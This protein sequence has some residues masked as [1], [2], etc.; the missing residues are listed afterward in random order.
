M[1]SASSHQ[2][3]AL[4]WSIMMP[5]AISSAGDDQRQQ[6]AQDQ[7]ETGAWLTEHDQQRAEGGRED[8]RGQRHERAE[9]AEDDRHPGRDIHVGVQQ[10]WGCQ[11]QLDAQ[12]LGVAVYLVEAVI[13]GG[14]CGRLR[15]NSGRDWFT[16]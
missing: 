4:R 3:V 14:L 16:G 1:P 5:P 7:S 8:E 6:R 15:A 9:N 13:P 12:L 10:T 2:P 11:W